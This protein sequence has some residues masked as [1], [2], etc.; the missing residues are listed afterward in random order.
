[1]DAN[2]F[3]SKRLRQL[4]EY[5]LGQAKGRL[6]ARA[7]ID[8]AAIPQ[9]LPYLFMIDVE[10]APR[11]FRFRLIGTQ[12]CTWAGRDV[13]GMYLDDPAYGPRG[14]IITRQYAE[15]VERGVAYYAEQ[16]AARPERDYVFY[17][18]LVLP[19]AADGR[20]VDILLCGVD[21]LPPTAELRAGNFRQVWDDG[22]P[23]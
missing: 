20:T 6:P 10:R 17:E 9:L 3:H 13:T 12:I 5:W 15:V 18:R 8:P 11:R 16:P 1:V 21:V 23:Q 2:A 7:D 22:P 14:E 4:Y 19:L